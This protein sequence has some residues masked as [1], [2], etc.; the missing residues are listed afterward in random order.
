MTSQRDLRQRRF[1]L[2]ERLERKFRKEIEETK[3]HKPFPTSPLTLWDSPEF[4]TKL[5]LLNNKRRQR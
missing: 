2:L 4:F 5:K 1:P 3:E